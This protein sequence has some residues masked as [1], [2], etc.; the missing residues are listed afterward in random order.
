[1]DAE[2]AKT[3]SKNYPDVFLAL[4]KRMN[5]GERLE[6][7]RA[8]EKDFPKYFKAFYTADVASYIRQLR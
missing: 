6:L 5:P 2:N 8:F 7:P 3:L 4:L 1:M